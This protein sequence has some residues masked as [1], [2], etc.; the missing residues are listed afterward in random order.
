MFE[1]EYSNWKRH[2]PLHH[3]NYIIEYESL[4]SRKNINLLYLTFNLRP[5]DQNIYKCNYLVILFISVSFIII[6]ISQLNGLFR[7]PE[8]P[9]LYINF[10]RYA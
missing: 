3:L 7:L 6:F 2:E 8:H 1:I 4:K 10:T 9:L 5:N